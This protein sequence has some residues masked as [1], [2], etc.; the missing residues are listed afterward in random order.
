MA[1][2]QIDGSVSYSLVNVFLE[3]RYLYLHVYNY[4]ASWKMEI[5][6]LAKISK[7]KESTSKTSDCLFPQ[8]RRKLSKST[9]LE[10]SSISPVSKK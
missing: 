2:F 9:M 3:S 10:I 8:S 7:I 5:Y 1:L 4:E 6:K